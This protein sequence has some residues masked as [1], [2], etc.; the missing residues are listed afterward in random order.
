MIS[1]EKLIEVLNSINLPVGN[2]AVDKIFSV[3]EN[4]PSA[5]PEQK[6]GRWIKI[7]PANIYECSECGK[8]VMTDDICAYQFCH[9]CGAKM[10]GTDE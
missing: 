6:I 7:S 8:N 2:E 9:G 3:I 10:E 5:Q 1:R 4:M